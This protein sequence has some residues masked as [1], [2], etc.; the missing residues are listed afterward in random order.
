MMR[1]RS[2][3]DGVGSWAKHG[4]ATIANP[5]TEAIFNVIAETFA[6]RGAQT[7]SA[8]Q[9]QEAFAVGQDLQKAVSAA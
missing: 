9:L 7:R 6:A 5:I 2:A 1:S 3:C 4:V 8:I